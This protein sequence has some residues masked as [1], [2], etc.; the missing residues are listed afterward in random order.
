VGDLLKPVQG[1]IFGMGEAHV[2]L[3]AAMAHEKK[4]HVEADQQNCVVQQEIRMIE[5]QNSHAHCAA[6]DDVDQVHQ[7][8]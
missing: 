8:D 1:V 7:Q 6:D 4:N 2:G 5:D 3:E